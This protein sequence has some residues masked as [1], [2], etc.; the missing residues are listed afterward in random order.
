MSNDL[1]A[2]DEWYQAERVSVAQY[3]ALIQW[4]DDGGGIRKRGRPF[5]AKAEQAANAPDVMASAARERHKRAFAAVERLG[6][7]VA[8]AVHRL[9]MMDDGDQ[10][11][12]LVQRG[13]S[14]VWVYYQGAR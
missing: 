7:S 4:R 3:Q 1:T 10:R 13:A 9:V 12:E 14:V 6:D 8:K 11:Q 2:L 5:K